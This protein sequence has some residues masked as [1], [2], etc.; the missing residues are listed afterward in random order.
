MGCT[1]KVCEKPFYNSRN[2]RHILSA[3]RTARKR[4]QEPIFNNYLGLP[5]G[6]LPHF[7]ASGDTETITAG[8]VYSMNN[9]SDKTK[10]K[11]HGAL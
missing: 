2:Y 6:P 5:Q 3:K 8:L 1:L 9:T 11:H 4:S 10:P 7:A